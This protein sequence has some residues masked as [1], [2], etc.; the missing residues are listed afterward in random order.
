MT[1]DLSAPI[2]T[3]IAAENRGDTESLAQCKTRCVCQTV[4]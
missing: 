1:V 3:Y 4:V 2:A